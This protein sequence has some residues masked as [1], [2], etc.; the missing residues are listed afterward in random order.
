M[1]LD[2][3]DELERRAEKAT[4]YVVQNPMYKDRETGRLVKKYDLAPAA[5]HGNL[6][7]LLDQD[8]NPFRGLERPTRELRNGLQNF[9]PGDSVLLIGNPILI[10]LTAVIASEYCDQI[11]FLQWSG[12]SQKYVAVDV[13]LS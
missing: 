6:V 7:Y 12:K 9:A 10:G 11:I 1:D 4:V 13:D 8:V 2:K 3:R 5:E